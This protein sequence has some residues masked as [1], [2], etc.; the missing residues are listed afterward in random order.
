MLA[1]KQWTNAAKLSEGLILR[2][3]DRG[4]HIG[5]TLGSGQINR[6]YKRIAKQANLDPDRISKISGYSFRVGAAIPG[7]KIHQTVAYPTLP[8]IP[9]ATGR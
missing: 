7:K 4:E 1:I 9:L 5:D 2:S 6:I 8:F 3:V